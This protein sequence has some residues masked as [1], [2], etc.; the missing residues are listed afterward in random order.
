M[1]A[2][3]EKPERPGA[4]SNFHQNVFALARVVC[5]AG[6]IMRSYAKKAVFCL[7]LALL[8]LPWPLSFVTSAEAGEVTASCT[9]DLPENVPLERLTDDS[10][11]TRLTLHKRKDLSVV[12]PAC[13]RPS[14]YVTWFARPDVLTVTE[15]NEGGK[16]IRTTDE[17]P[18]TPFERYELDPACRKVVLSSAEECTFSTLRVFDG[19]LPQEL[20]CFDDPIQQADMLVI[21]GQPQALFEELGGLVPLYTGKYQIKTVFCFLSEDSQILQ[22]TAGD[23]LPLG[24]ALRALWSLGYREAPFLGGF[25][26][27]D[28]SDLEDVRPIWSN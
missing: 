10:L 11:L 27:H 5:Y 17:I 14:L 12:L 22:A 7:L 19:P 28:I 23:P 15:L 18:A 4:P 21:L 3:G 13:S 16:L 24:E 8:L 9:Y 6:S 20:L 1:Q 25:L 26:D 2:E